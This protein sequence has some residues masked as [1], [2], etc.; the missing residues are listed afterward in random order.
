MERGIPSELPTRLVEIKAASGSFRFRLTTTFPEGCQ[1]TALSYRWGSDTSYSLRAD[2]EAHMRNF[3]STT[4]LPNT[5]RDACIITSRLGLSYI[6]IDRLCIFQDSN[7]D[8]AYESS[9]MAQ[10]Y[11]NAFCTISAACASNEQSG[12]FRRRRTSSILPLDLQSCPFTEGKVR[13]MGNSILDEEGYE[14]MDHLTDRGWIFQERCLSRRTLY[15]G[16]NQV[17]WECRLGVFGEACPSDRTLFEFWKKPLAVY[18]EGDWNARAEAWANIVD[19]YSSKRLTYQSDRLPAL[20]GMAYEMQHPLKD[21]YL[22]GL[23]RQTLLRDLCWVPD[24]PIGTPTA[25]QAPSWSWASH[26]SHV[27]F[28]DGAR[29]MGEIR[30]DLA[31]VKQAHVETASENPFGQVRNGWITLSGHLQLVQLEPL[32]AHL[33]LVQLGRKFGVTLTATVDGAPIS[34]LFTFHPDNA[35]SRPQS[36]NNTQAYCLPLFHDCLPSFEYYDFYM[37]VYCLLLVPHSG[38]SSLSNSIHMGQA[39]VY[40]RIAL[41][42]M[43]F[44]KEKEKDVLDWILEAPLQ[45][46]TIV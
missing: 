25:Y 16:R 14:M 31:T 3:V 15:F 5:L 8:W 44:S 18:P 39:S 40:E 28:R 27:Q 20:S 23:W 35:D 7:S 33:Q 12:C 26:S 17:Y 42:T 19:V 45:E 9:R 29:K 30:G 38:T 10:V 4:E 34:P 1:Y 2:T 46:V 6:W 36:W 22:A 41:G 37:Q 43:S 24:T 13:I 32:S 21:Q 11:R